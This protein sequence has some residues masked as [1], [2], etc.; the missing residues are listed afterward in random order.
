MEAQRLGAGVENSSV[1]DTSLLAIIMPTMATVHTMVG[2]VLGIWIRYR[3]VGV[4]LVV[5]DIALL[6]GV[7]QVF[8]LDVP[9]VT[10]VVSSTLERVQH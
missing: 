7:G 9:V 8:L 3:V 1:L 6:V 4:L 10:G 2:A 5:V